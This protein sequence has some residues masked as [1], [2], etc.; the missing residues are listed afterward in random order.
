MA[1]CRWLVGMALLATIAACNRS[2][3]APTG[4]VAL[5]NVDQVAHELGRDD[6]LQATL[7]TKQ[8]EARERLQLVSAQLQRQIEQESSKASAAPSMEKMQALDALKREASERF[9]REV[10]EAQQKI[11]RLRQATV[12]E[13]K[14]E[15]RPVAKQIAAQ[16]GLGIVLMRRED[17]ILDASP[18]SDITDEVIREMKKANAGRPTPTMPETPV[19]APA[20]T[21][22]P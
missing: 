20:P 21:T 14:N 13:F 22:Q 12:A 15:V 11:E 1:R 5:V 10:T 18:E 9:Q 8:A 7:Q 19:T 4:R 6:A 2:D 17:V 16:R 3:S